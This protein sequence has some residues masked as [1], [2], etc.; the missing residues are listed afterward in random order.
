MK[1]KAAIITISILLA[2]FLCLVTGAVRIPVAD[3]MAILMG[4]GGAKPSW[5]YIVIENRLPQ[6]VTALLGGGALAITGLM[7]QTAFRNSLAGPGIFGVSSGASLGVA[8]VMLLPGVAFSGTSVGLGGFLE[9]TAAAFAG[10][11]AVMGVIMLIS[12]AI[13]NNTM[14][15]IAGIMIGYIASSAISL[16]NYFAGAEG[17]QSYMMWGLG[18]FGSVTLAQL[19]YFS[20]GTIIGLMAS[21]LLIK[22]LNAMLLGDSYAANLGINPIRLRNMLLIVT[23]WLTAVVTAYCGP[24]SFIGLA[25]PHIARMIFHTDDHSV[26]MPATI[27]CGALTGL[28][29]CL[30]CTLPGESGLLPLNA[31]TPLIGAPVI[32][33]VILRHG[34]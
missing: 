2:F 23:G 14:L 17:V 4:D 22:P 26:I 1:T 11:M 30:I 5:R 7:L 9:V 19:S 18:S 33:Y 25:V 10:A 29:C 3:V 34:K 13:R 6:A 24:I 8:L 31:V 28:V 12:L 20:A 21:L 15:L 16:L 32:I 27:G